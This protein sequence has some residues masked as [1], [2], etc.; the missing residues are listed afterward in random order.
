MDQISE[1]KQKLDIVDVVGSYVSLKKS[2]RNYKA[3]CPFH[4]EKTP[5]FMVSPDLQ[6]YK[7]FGCGAAGDIFGFVQNI[8]GIDFG[9]ALELLADKAGVKL[10]KKYIDSQ[11][12]LKKRIYFINDVTCKF[13]EYLLL[14]HKA[15]KQA[16]NYLTKDRGLSLDTIK[17]FRLGYAPD[18]WD[19]LY[20]FLL[21][22]NMKPEELLSAGVIVER[23]S[24][25][26]KGFL[27]KF[28]GRVVFPLTESDG[29]IVGFTG[30]TILNQDPKY[31]N[32]SETLVFHKTFFL[33]GL[34]KNRVNIKQE[35]AVFVEGQMDLISAYQAGI[36]NVISV[37]GTSITENQLKLLS[38]YTKDI[39]FCF[40][41]DFAGIKASYRAIDLAEKQDFNIRAALIPQPYKDLDEV[42]KK[43][44]ELAKET[45]KNVLP[46]YDFFIV[47]MLKQYDKNTALGKKRIMEEL[48]P[49]FS[50]ISNKVLLDHYTKEISK[51]L[52]ISEDVVFQMLNKGSLSTEYFG[53]VSTEKE[54]K[55]SISKPNPEGYAMAII[56]KSP[57]EIAQKYVSKLSIKDF[58]SSAIQNILKEL[59]EYL[60]DRKSIFNMNSFVK[61]VEDEYKDYATELFMMDLESVIDFED[62][63]GVNKE[64]NLLLQRIKKDSAKRQ[65]KDLSD[66]IRLAEREGD[67]ELLSNLTEKF[68]K[69]SK[70]LI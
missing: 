13:Y 51:E 16:L 20:K 47:T 41:A 4:S 52:N 10:E 48:I 5:S 70:D 46:V 56:F 63:D 67:K 53:N 19:L 37:S 40:D 34:D 21:S 54:E 35:G 43:D 17:T 7:C 14:K 33:F 60:K 66:K 59:K 23:N 8:E 39:T 57:L 42:I 3:N 44:P 12:S 18:N 26:G 61:K 65:L 45:L 32:T 15:G 68:E 27:D 9:A 31:L 50:K 28:R 64:L 55:P 69:L 49:I 62:Q 6:I 24:E 36:K 25:K 22:K 38:R 1:I 29:N 30:R 2:G 58:E 11:Q